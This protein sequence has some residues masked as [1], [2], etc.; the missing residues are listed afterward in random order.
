MATWKNYKRQLR[1]SG[2]IRKNSGEDGWQPEGWDMDTAQH[3]DD[4]Y[5]EARHGPWKAVWKG[6]RLADVFHD[7]AESPLHAIQAGEYDWQRGQMGQVTPE[8]LQQRLKDWSTDS[9]GEYE[10]NELP[11]QQ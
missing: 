8:S 11:Y 2:T 6:G 7:E 1:R 3:P 10:R 5:V 4:P 9:G